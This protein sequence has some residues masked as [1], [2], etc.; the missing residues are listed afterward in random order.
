[1]PVAIDVV[2]EGDALNTRGF[3][4][5]GALSGIGLLTFGFLWECG[6]IWGPG[7]NV[8]WFPGQPDAITTNWADTESAISTTWAD[9]D[10]PITTNWA[11]VD[12][13]C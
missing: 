13:V 5:L 6:A 7:P 9:C 1:V 12:G 10:T 2:I 8:T 4:N 11:D 3:Q